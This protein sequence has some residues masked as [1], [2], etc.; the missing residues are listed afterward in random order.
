GGAA[1]V[2]SAGGEIG[3]MALLAGRP[4]RCFAPAV[5]TG[6]GA[7]EDDAAVPQRAFRRSVDEIFAGSCLVATRY[8]DPFGNAAAGFEDT[9]A[10]LVEWR[11]LDAANRRIAVCVG[12]SFWKRRRV[13]EFVASS[14]GAP[15]FRR[16]SRGALAAAVGNTGDPP[17]A[18]AV[19]ASRIPDGLPGAAAENG[20]PLI[21]VEDG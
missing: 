11:R 20:V 2:Y 15:M 21:R 13:A 9:L 18:I 1:R 17:R 3:L 19:W 10:L 7:T 5:Y 12:M 14:A 4:T 16:R 8:L 6:G